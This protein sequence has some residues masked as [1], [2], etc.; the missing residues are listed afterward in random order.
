MNPP[1]G[2][3]DNEI[4][5]IFIDQSLLISNNKIYIIHKKNCHFLYNYL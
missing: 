1:F 4:L 2:T 3:K 5:K